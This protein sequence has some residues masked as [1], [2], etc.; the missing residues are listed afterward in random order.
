MKKILITLPTYNEE[1]ILKENTLRVYDFCQ[2]N[3]SDFDWK[4]LIADNG[5]VDKTVEIAEELS[6]NYPKISYFHLEEAGR[7]RALKKA[8]SEYEADIYTYMDIDLATDLNYF[9]DLIKAIAFE[10]YELAT[11]SRLKKGASVRRSFLRE[12]SSR[13]YNF[14]LRIFFKGYK[15]KD[16]QCGFKAISKKIKEEILPYIKNNGWFFDTELLIISFYKKFKIKEIPV[17]WQENRYLKRKSK[18]KI[19]SDALNNL[20]EIIKLKIFLLKK[21]YFKT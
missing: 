20:K 18:V 1:K 21:N 17:N 3:L 2:K 10:G 6:K 11:G 12:I 7:G 14:L 16:S 4:I 9:K 8:W 13:F 15:I 5:S 19:F